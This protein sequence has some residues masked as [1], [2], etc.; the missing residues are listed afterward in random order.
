M[1]SIL[2]IDAAWT[3]AAP[4]GV[5]LLAG[6]PGGW[7]LL[8]SASSYGAFAEP[9]AVARTHRCDPHGLLLAAAELVGGPVDLVAVDMPLAHEAIVAR[10]AADDAISRTFGSRHCSTH[11]PSAIRPGKVSED[12]RSALAGAGYRL[13]VRPEEIRRPAVIEVYPHPALLALTG[14]PMRL[15]YKAGKTRTYWPGRSPGERRAELL[16]VWAEIVDALARE[17]GGMEKLGPLP[18]AEASTRELKAFEDRLDSVV[19]AWVGARAIE[20]GCDLY[21]DEIATIWVPKG[22]REMPNNLSGSRE[23]GVE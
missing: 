15:P 10:R 7:H 16:K 9:D 8:R 22:R 6:E 12:L 14:R 17:I 19:C 13:A 5:A 11:T 2:G 21:G 20:K 1:I 3:T 23:V 4:S 18:A